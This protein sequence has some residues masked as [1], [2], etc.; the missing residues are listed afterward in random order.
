MNNG[1]YQA[2]FGVRARQIALEVMAHNL[3]NAVNNG[4]KADQSFFRALR[5]E[6]DRGVASAKELVSR[7]SIEV[8]TGI[9]FSPGIIRQ[10]GRE[11]DLALE[12]EGFLAVQTPAGRRYTR[13]GSLTLNAAGQLVTQEGYLVLGL[14]NGTTPGPITLPPGQ[15][16]INEQGVISVDGVEQAR[17]RLVTF[18]TLATLL[19]EG[20]NLFAQTDPQIQEQPA[21]RLRLHQGALESSN[22]NSIGE[23]ITMIRMAREFETLQRSIT[24]LTSDLGRIISQEVGKL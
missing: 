14:I 11:L 18:S 12:G 2:Y 22:V 5:A 17:L 9:D 8:S 7:Q 1:L 19:K 21:N 4:Y 3:A 24:I 13:N 20:G 16:E 23:M 6:I 15:I 10:T